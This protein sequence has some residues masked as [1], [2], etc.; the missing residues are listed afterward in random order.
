LTAE[1]ELVS[2]EG[3]HGARQRSGTAATVDTQAATSPVTV[4]TQR[5]STRLATQL[6]VVRSSAVGGQTGLVA[7]GG[8]AVD[9]YV[10]P[11]AAPAVGSLYYQ[12]ERSGASPA[13]AAAP[14]RYSIGAASDHTT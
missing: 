10:A 13:S 7:G 4:T 11:T 8:A 14:Y 9:T 12:A 3:H 6:T 2:V 1:Q 5:P